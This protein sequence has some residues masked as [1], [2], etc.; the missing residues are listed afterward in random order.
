M[1]NTFNKL[2]ERIASI[3]FALTLVFDY[4]PEIGIS[5]KVSALVMILFIVLA[6]ITQDHLHYSIKS[7]KLEFLTVTS[8][9]LL[10]LILSLIGGESQNGLNLDN[11]IIWFLY[12]GS[13]FTIIVKYKRKKTYM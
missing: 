10:L 11:P 13:L 2:F 12:F 7:L 8:I 1:K 3:M 4:F 9:M 5:Y 6:V